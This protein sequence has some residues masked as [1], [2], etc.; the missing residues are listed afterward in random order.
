[1]EQNAVLHSAWNEF[2]VEA[3]IGL[4]L[5]KKKIARA[6]IGRRYFL[7]E[8]CRNDLSSAA[9]HSAAGLV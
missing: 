6:K 4:M 5:L 9:A 3:F 1:M 8:Q 2:A 7:V